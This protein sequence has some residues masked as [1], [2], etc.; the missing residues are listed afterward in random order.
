MSEI[1]VATKATKVTTT[2][3]SSSTVATTKVVV[4]LTGTDVQKWTDQLAQAREAIKAFEAMENEAK[5]ALQS[6][7]GDADFGAVEGINVVQT[8]N[9]KSTGIDRAI[10]KE[11]FPDAYTATYWEKP[12]RWFKVLSK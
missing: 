10:L 5:E 12:T 3:V 2:V 7:M 6:L 8:M 4:D 1:K 9:G 11:A